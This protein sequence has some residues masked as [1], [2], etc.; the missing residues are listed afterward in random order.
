MENWESVFKTKQNV[1]A[2]IARSVLEE[3]GIT[4]VIIN[5]QDSVY[6]VIGY[7]EVFVPLNDAALAL[8]ILSNESAL[9]E[10]E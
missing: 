10:S 6:P 5:K 2:E 8:T 4:A 9:K 1:R 3:N 7:S